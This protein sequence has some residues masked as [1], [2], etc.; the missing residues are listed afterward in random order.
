MYID[1]DCVVMHETDKAY[2]IKHEGEEAWIAKS[3]I[4]SM[5]H[6]GADD[7]SIEIPE[8]LAEEK[9]II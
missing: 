2:L 4:I 8:W 9:G 1:L 7:Y 5:E 6:Q 3:Q